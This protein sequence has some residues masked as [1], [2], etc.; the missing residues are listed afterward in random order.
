MKTAQEKN[1]IP[2]IE[3]IAVKILRVSS[4]GNARGDVLEKTKKA[5]LRVTKGQSFGFSQRLFTSKNM[6]TSQ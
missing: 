2:M 6:K 1:L 5:P 3:I 4:S